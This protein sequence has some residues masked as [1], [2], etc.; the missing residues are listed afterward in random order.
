MK[1]ETYYSRWKKIFEASVGG[2]DFAYE[3]SKNGQDLETI[4]V[5]SGSRP[6]AVEDRIGDAFD[7]FIQNNGIDEFRKILG[8]PRNYDYERTHWV[9]RKIVES[10]L[11]DL[12]KQIGIGR[13]AGRHPVRD[14]KTNQE[15][16]ND[17]KCG[18]SYGQIEKKYK[19]SKN[20][21]AGIVR[22]N[23]TK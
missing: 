4:T 11:D 2:V 22:R 3:M 20:Q 12:L 9:A 17:K 7:R 19:I 18:L 8:I 5:C 23:K 21:A 1:K 13:G 14:D 10:K 15:I 16:V 6:I